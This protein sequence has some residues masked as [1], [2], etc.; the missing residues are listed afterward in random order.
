MMTCPSTACIPGENREAGGRR[1]LGDERPTGYSILS[2][3]H[4]MPPPA[5]RPSA[6]D[7]RREGCPGRREGDLL[8]LFDLPAVHLLLLGLSASFRALFLLL[9]F[10]CCSGR[11]MLRPSLFLSGKCSAVAAVGDWAYIFSR[12]H[13]LSAVHRDLHSGMSVLGDGGNRTS[14]LLF[15]PSGYLYHLFAENLQMSAMAPVLFFASSE[16]HRQCRY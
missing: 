15:L 9:F 6:T 1:R 4:S 11:Y 8:K 16:K 13:F 2:F 10:C 12:G 14:C 7:W 3:N 5:D